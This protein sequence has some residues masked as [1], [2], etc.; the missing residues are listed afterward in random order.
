MDL[1]K[2]TELTG[3]T[4]TPENEA[5]VNASIRRTKSQLETQLGFSLKPKNLYTELGKVRFEGDLPLLNDTDNLLAPDEQ[6]GGYKLF[7]YN[8]KDYYF[9]TD[10]FKNIYH[11]KLVKPINDGE[12]ITVFDLDHV[13]AK[14]ER[15]GIGRFIERYDTWFTWFW[16]LNWF[17]NFN[18]TPSNGMMIAVDADWVTCYS[19]DINYLWADTVTYYTSPSYGLAS[20]SVDGH[21][22]S[23][24]KE[25]QMSPFLTADGV[26]T[27][28]R[29]AGPYGSL[30]RNPVR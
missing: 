23:R 21:S 2:Y 27:L 3:I 5:T 1:D 25:A 20:E 22:W 24:S 9:H 17:S 28:S 14:Y 10:P 16:Y 19:D 6:E 11:V 15:D 7:P 26:K 30:G 13:S 29:Y 8:E 12:F 18:E 4:V